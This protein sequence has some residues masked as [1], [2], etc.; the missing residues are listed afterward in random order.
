[1]QSLSYVY[2]IGG[3]AFFIWLIIHN[4]K[5]NKRNRERGPVMDYAVK[6]KGKKPR[7]GTMRRDA[8]VIDLKTEKKSGTLKTAV[9]FDDGYIFTTYAAKE[10]A[11]T[12]LMSY[13][14]QYTVDTEVREKILAEAAAQHNR[15]L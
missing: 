12:G 10:L 8:K 5:Q 7:G 9:T 14:V 6:G 2:I 13:N 11:T 3:S 1:M 4:H 15:D